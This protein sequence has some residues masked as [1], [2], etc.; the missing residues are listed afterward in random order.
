MDTLQTSRS[1]TDKFAISL[2]L[3]CAAHCLVLPLLTVLLPSIAALGLENEAFHAWMV[4]LVI[5]TS[6]YALTMGCK[7]H[8][9]Y[10][11]LALGLLGIALLVSAVLGEEHITE[12]LEKSLTLAGASLIAWSHLKNYRLCQKHT[13]D[14]HCHEH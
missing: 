6:L 5:P 10:S 13:N 8:K 7:Q 2:S 4:I 12:T 14:C 3:L 1:I 11:F 9:N